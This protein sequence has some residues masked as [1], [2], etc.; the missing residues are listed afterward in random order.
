MGP[1]TAPARLLRG[2]GIGG[3]GLDGL[4]RFG[5]IRCRFGPA[6]R[7]LIALGLPDRVADADVVLRVLEVVF[8]VDPVSMGQG[9]PCE[10]LVTLRELRGVSLEAFRGAFAV[11]HMVRGDG[12]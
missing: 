4:I 2:L 10:L 11:E 12:S 8:G 7:S 5:R 9:V 1:G 3:S 6:R